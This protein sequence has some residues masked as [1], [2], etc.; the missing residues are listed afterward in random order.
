[1]KT[2]YAD[3]PAFQGGLSIFLAGP[4]PRGKDVVS[5]RP[6]A[7]EILESLKFDGT[8]LIPERRDWSVKFDYTDQTE[9]EFAGLS[10]ATVILFW[11]PRQMGTMPALTTNVEFGYWIATS[12]DK[13]IYGRPDTAESVRYLDWMFTKRTTGKQVQKTLEETLRAAVE[14]SGKSAA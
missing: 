3:E 2:L 7:I 10:K 6:K 1:M 4:T 14:L 12:P 11:V 8:V 9:W 13:L 5:W